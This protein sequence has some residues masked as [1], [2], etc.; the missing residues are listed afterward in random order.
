MAKYKTIFTDII[1]VFPCYNE[2]CV[3]RPFHLYYHLLTR[4]F[5]HLLFVYIF[6]LDV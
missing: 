2:R 1:S 4:L 5:A 6:L 3:N